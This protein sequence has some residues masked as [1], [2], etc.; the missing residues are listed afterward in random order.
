M[1][2]SRGVILLG[3]VLLVL[4]ATG[5]AHEPTRLQSAYG[6]S[7]HA[8]RVSQILHPQ[9]HTNLAPV[10]ELDGKAAKHTFERYRSTF[11]K[12]SPPPSFLISVGEI[13]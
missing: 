4:M 10:A 9:A 7:Y 11:E 12:P 1:H 8:A 2:E 13:R 6:R 5:C 3:M